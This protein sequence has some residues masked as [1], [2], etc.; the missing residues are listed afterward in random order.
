MKSLFHKVFNTKSGLGSKTITRISTESGSW[1]PHIYRLINEN[2]G[3]TMVFY[4]GG[5]DAGDE[6]LYDTIAD[7]FSF[8]Q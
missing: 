6:T 7:T 2:Y 1:Y 8:E 3:F 5:L 4:S